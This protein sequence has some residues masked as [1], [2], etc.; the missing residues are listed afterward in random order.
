MSAPHD[1]YGRRGDTIKG[2]FDCLGVGHRFVKVSSVRAR[3]RRDVKATGLLAD[4]GEQ[5]SEG[6]GR[7]GRVYRRL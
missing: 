1:P 3:I 5:H 6:P 4:T 7:P 2:C